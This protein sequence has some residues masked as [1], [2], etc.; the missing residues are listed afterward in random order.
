MTMRDYDNATCDYC[1][2][3]VS[4]SFGRE[5]GDHI[6]PLSAYHIKCKD[7][8][9]E[10]EHKIDNYD[11]IRD[12][13]DQLEGLAGDLLR[14]LGIAALDNIPEANALFQYWGEDAKE[15]MFND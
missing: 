11:D 15:D 3:R 9:K 4:N 1:N 13:L 7:E 12:D 10:K 6:G 14:V 5:E 2:C 8:H